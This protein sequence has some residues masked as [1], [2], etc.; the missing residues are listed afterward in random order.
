MPA[1]DVIRQAARDAGWTKSGPTVGD[2]ASL[3]KRDRFRTDTH[4]VT[5]QYNAR[6]AIG[7]ASIAVQTDG[8]VLEHLYPVTNGKL[9]RVQLWLT[10]YGDSK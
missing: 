6:G 9:T 4:Q 3:R 5:V 10:K 8:T 2:V 7:E 1:R